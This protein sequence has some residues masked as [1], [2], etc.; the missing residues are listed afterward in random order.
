MRALTK[1][2]GL[3]Q[4]LKDGRWHSM[5]EMLE[6]GGYRYTQRVKD[7]REGADGLPPLD[8]EAEGK[9]NVWRYRARLQTSPKEAPPTTGP[10]GLPQTCSAGP[11]EAR[12][13]ATSTLRAAA[14][15]PLL[16]RSGPDTSSGP[17][18]TG[19]RR[20]RDESPFSGATNVSATKDV[21]A[22]PAPRVRELLPPVPAGAATRNNRGDDGLHG[23]REGMEPGGSEAFALESATREIACPCG[24]SNPCRKCWSVCVAPGH[25]Q[26]ECGGAR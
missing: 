13:G 10:V 4:L 8:I 22:V 14:L 5:A 11:S 6:A 12:H 2:A 7:V 15:A 17:S 3:R 19:E 1:T 9:G 16:G 18:F 26:H 25:A 24:T 21:P 23:G 20:F